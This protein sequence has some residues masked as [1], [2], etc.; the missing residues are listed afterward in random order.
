MLGDR[1]IR[2]LCLLHYYLSVIKVIF[3]TFIKKVMKVILP[4]SK[5]RYWPSW[6]EEQE[7]LCTKPPPPPTI[8]YII[9]TNL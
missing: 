9:K 7:L 8:V 6:Q 5:H 2:V 1:Q 4:A 3:I